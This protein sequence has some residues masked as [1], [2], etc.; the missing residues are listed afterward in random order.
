M[1]STNCR[2][3]RGRLSHGASVEYGGSAFIQLSIKYCRGVMPELMLVAE[4]GS[5]I[6][7][8]LS[9]CA[10]RRTTSRPKGAGGL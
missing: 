3:G 1:A 9:A 6:A 7:L 2:R 4:S 5:R 10:R 8:K